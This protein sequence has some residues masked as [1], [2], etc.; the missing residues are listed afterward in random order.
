VARD[1]PPGEREG[2]EDVGGRA[3]VDE[4]RKVS[5]VG[6]AVHAVDGFLEAVDGLHRIDLHAG[7]AGSGFPAWL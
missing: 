3:G 4:G 2:D 7:D 6:E 5:H 1:E